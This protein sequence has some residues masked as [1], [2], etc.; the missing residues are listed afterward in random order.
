MDAVFPRPWAGAGR[1]SVLPGGRAATPKLAGCR[2]SM[3]KTQGSRRHPADRQAQVSRASVQATALV[4][5]SAPTT[6]GA[7]DVGRRHRQDLAYEMGR[8][9]SRQSESWRPRRESNP[10][11]RICSP[12]RNHSATRPLSHRPEGLVRR[13]PSGRP[14]R[15][16]RSLAEP[17]AKGQRPLGDLGKK[18]GC[19]CSASR[20]R[21][22][23][24]MPPQGRR[25]KKCDGIVK[26][27]ARTLLRLGEAL[28]RPP[29]AVPDSSV[30][31]ASDC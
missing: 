23:G 19:A 12:L 3:P 20:T 18:D 26:S 24:T 4:L 6:W 7:N 22:T 15:G 29:I 5:P 27:P 10:R 31:R 11:T 13:P 9:P 28:C 14:A 2:G 25:S 21:S 17:H 16:E 30:G 1:R 8:R